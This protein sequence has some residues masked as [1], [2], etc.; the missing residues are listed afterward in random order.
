METRP[1]ARDLLSRPEIIEAAARLLGFSRAAADF[2]TAHPH[3]LASLA[4]VRQRT[5]EELLEEARQDTARSGPAVGLRRFRRRSAYR[6][7]ARDLSGAVVDEA[8]EELTAIAQ[9]CLRVAVDSVPN[10]TDLAV[11]GMGK[12]GGGELNYSSDVDV[13]FLHAST[14]GAAHETGAKAAAAV[15]ALLSEPTEEGVALRVDASLRPEGR[16]GALSRSLDS[17]IEYYGEHA[18]TWER[19]ALVKARPV[20]GDIE[21]GERF[22]HAVTALVYPAVLPASAIEDVRASK[23][24]IEEH[25]RASGKEHV[26][27]KRGRGGIRDVE[28]AVQL[29]QLVHG[30]R[31]E[32]LRATGTLPALGALADR[33]YVSPADGEALAGSYRFLR[34]LEHRLQLVRDL[35]THELPTDRAALGPLARAMGMSSAEHLRDEYERHTSIVRGLHERLF[36][37]PLM[38]AFAGPAPAPGLDRTATEEL[39]SALGFADPASAYA[40]LAGV[41]DP[42][43]RMGR[44]LGTLF[45]LIAPT[46]AFAA[47][48]D[49]ALVRFGRVVDGLKGAD[50]LADG[51]SDR[52]DAARRLA[53]L[54]AVSSSF[55]DALVAR[56]SMAFTV[57]D[58]PA[59]QRPLFPSDGQEELIRVAA[60]YA[61][62]E[63]EVPETGRLLTMVAD[64]VIASALATEQPPVPVAVI[65]FGKLGSEELSFASDLD[66]MF[67]YE[68]EGS[69]D[70]R[71]ATATAERVLGAVRAS[72]WPADADLR[73]EG[74]SGPLARSM[75]SYL[76]YWERWAET[77]EY[78][79]LLRARF[80]AGDEKLGRRFLSN[81][82]DFAYPESLTF[83]QVAAIRRMRVRIEELRVKPKDARRFHFKLGYGSL[84][85]VQFAVELSLMRHGF[86]HPEVRRTNTLEAI[87]ALAA[88]RLLEDSVALALSEAHL[89]LT[90]VKMAVEIEQRVARGALPTSPE[91]QAALAR[92]LGYEERARHRFLQDY[93]SITH[94]ARRAMERVFYGEEG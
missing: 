50:P 75:A 40:V 8:M 94:R 54:I 87:E 44:V 26:E 7:A 22:V 27:V 3:E 63:L 74:R 46:L 4:D 81:A 79:A 15:M 14:G 84:S 38:E 36:Y 34:R 42:A 1:G 80:V 56:P 91:G 55:A 71:T 62:G 59:R 65:G 70:F 66:V 19:Q 85:D 89:F 25:V 23:A 2:F 12:L 64:G 90:R 45:P 61:S 93:M 52:P 68:G 49:S 57:L 83:E 28:F 32:R 76:E 69:E 47:L 41:I 78:Q 24:R 21:L 60:A 39:L 77:W 48:P 73:P 17:M 43:T 35:Q 16:S 6:V 31:D 29:L 92:R 33:G 51:F 53:A 88:A 13:L 82:A 11:V 67:V 10:A 18:A 58:L 86:D 72:G 20:A 30:R 37:R 5:A 9:A